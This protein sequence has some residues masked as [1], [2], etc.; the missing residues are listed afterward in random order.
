MHPLACAAPLTRRRA[1]AGFTLIEVAVTM[2]VLALVAAL[3]L[4]S[5]S[6]VRREEATMAATVRTAADVAVR[7]SQWVTLRV[8][9]DGYWSVR[10]DLDVDTASLASGH[11]TARIDAP[12]V[13][14]LSPLGACL[15]GSPTGEDPCALTGARRGARP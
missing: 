1:S 7:R 11:T 15:T 14:R 12:L 6:P 9:P 10:G 8:A 13:V 3:T 4:P 2:L 5:L